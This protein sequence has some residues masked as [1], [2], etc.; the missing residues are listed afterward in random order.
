[1]DTK[2]PVRGLAIIV[3]IILIVLTA[4]SKVKEPPPQSSQESTF[5][6]DI[7]GTLSGETQTEPEEALLPAQGETQ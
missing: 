3:I 5:V 1:M 7:P 6:F 2:K 4:C